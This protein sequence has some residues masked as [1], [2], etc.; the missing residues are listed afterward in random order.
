MPVA[1]RDIDEPE[2]SHSSAL[3]IDDDQRLAHLD[4]FGIPHEDVRDAAARARGNEFISFI[5]SM[6]QTVVSVLTFCPI[7]TKRLRTGS[8]L[9]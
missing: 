2:S 1:Q 5:T 3:R 7:S 8:G 6:M 9:R 4:R